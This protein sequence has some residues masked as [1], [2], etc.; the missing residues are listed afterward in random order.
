MGFVVVLEIIYLSLLHTLRKVYRDFESFKSR[1]LIIVVSLGHGL[2]SVLLVGCV[3]SCPSQ[4]APASTVD[5]LPA[6]VPQRMGTHRFRNCYK[7]RARRQRPA[8]YFHFPSNGFNFLSPHYAN[9]R[10]TVFTVC[11]LELAN[12]IYLRPKWRR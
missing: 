10:L 4:G 7:T 11:A 8:A 12:V 3:D 2:Y 5:L 9:S 6:S 1:I